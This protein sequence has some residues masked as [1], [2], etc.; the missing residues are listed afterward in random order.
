[1]GTTHADAA[2]LGDWT[3]STIGASWRRYDIQLTIYAALLACVGLAM[4]YTNTI[5]SGDPALS[6]GSTFTRGLLWLA[7][8]VTA[9][10][11]TTV[12]DYRW[13]RTFAWPIYVLNL[14]LLVVTLAIGTGPSGSARWITIGEITIQASE[15]SKVL[16]IAVLANFLANRR[17][18]IG[19]ARTILGAC[20]LVAP[21]F[22]LVLLEPD[23]G[24][25]LVFLAILAGMLFMSGASLRWLFALALAGAAAIPLA[26]TYVLEDYQ[27]Q[28]LT[29]FLDPEADPLGAGYQLVQAQIAVGA[30][31]ATGRGLTNGLQN[32]LDFLPV[33]TTD[34]VFAVLAEEL[35]FIGGILLF[36]LFVALLWRLFVAAWRSR[37]PFGSFFAAGLA[38]AVFFQFVVNIGMVIGLM[39]ITG[40]PL[41]FVTHGGASLISLSIALGIVQSVNIRQT[42]A[43]W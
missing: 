10:V 26:W 27:K 29:A 9:N 35:G 28:R 40:I 22:A 17:D 23:L 31:G 38:S 6:P 7:I 2:R 42:R 33:Q 16:T 15:I 12:V 37:D 3:T 5:A 30:G 18:R 36:V 8:A 34:F 32:Q 13:L 11:V 14:A 21:A 1:M 24:T 4:A 25:S 19:S 43:E 41:P 39:P 20:I